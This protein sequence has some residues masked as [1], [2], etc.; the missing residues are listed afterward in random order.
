MSISKADYDELVRL[1]ASRMEYVRV[2]LNGKPYAVD[3]R[4]F[5]I[6]IAGRKFKSLKRKDGRINIAAAIAGYESEHKEDA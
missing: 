6:E 4:G 5:T 1:R 3:A 2:G